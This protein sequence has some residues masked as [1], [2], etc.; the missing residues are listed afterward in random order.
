MKKSSRLPWLIG[1]LPLGAIVV[2]F[3]IFSMSPVPQ[4]AS[5]SRPVPALR[6]V[7]YELFR[8]QE[9][10]WAIHVLTID[11]TRQ[12]LELMTTLGRGSKIGLS[13]LT[14][15]LRL[16]PSEWGRPVAAIN[17][18][19]YRTEGEP[20]AG[21]PRGLQILAG[22]LVSAPAD[23]A[24]FWVDAQGN[25]RMG[26]VTGGF[27]VTWPDGSQT[28]FGLNEEREGSMAV[29]Y[30]SA[31][32]ASTGTS[33][34]TEYVLERASDGPWLP[35]SPGMHYQ[36]RIRQIRGG[37]NTPL[38]PD[39][40]V[41]SVGTFS[42][43]LSPRGAVGDM[44][45]IS[46]TTKPDLRG[47]KTAIGGGPVL[48]RGGQPRPGHVHKSMERHPRSAIG[49]NQKEILFVEV[50]GR[51]RGWSVGMTLPELA[52]YM[53]RLGCQE[54]V[55]LDGGG[56]AELW[57][58]GRIMNRPCYGHERQMANTLILVEKKEAGGTMNNPVLK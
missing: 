16:I 26:E 9:L 10:P 38:K 36:A 56:S 51:Q 5:D 47:V 22:E 42:R 14:E 37:G 33:G 48:V 20:Y 30:S 34:G 25:P 46:T 49:W 15:Q 18:D 3:L 23:R 41:L 45:K 32:G 39:I 50:D 27:A 53:V 24:C 11:R 40:L 57:F 54:A 44:L 21:D 29:L 1:A 6:G 4:I 28:P 55:G 31:V 17:G 8:V 52:E 7:S 43:L 13:G 58:N 2:S 12:D 35:L 19:F